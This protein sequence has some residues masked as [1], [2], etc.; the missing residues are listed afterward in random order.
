MIKRFTSDEIAFCQNREGVAESIRKEYWPHIRAKGYF[1]VVLPYIRQEK[2][3]EVMITDNMRN[4]DQHHSVVAQVID[5]GP[6]AYTDEKVCGGVAWAE[7]GDWIITPRIAGMRAARKIGQNDV[8]FRIIKEDDVVA[9]VSSPEEW[10]I[11]ISST[12]F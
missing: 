6:V 9:V 11:R 3:G 12:R 2:V 10:E 4:E 1:L 8:M 7:I 5:I